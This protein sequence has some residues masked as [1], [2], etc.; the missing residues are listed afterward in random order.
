MKKLLI[1]F[2]LVSCVS[3]NS[4]LESNTKKLDFNTDLNFEDFNELL[5]EYAKTSSYPNIDN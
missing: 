3:T 1:F 4:N 5:I 2:F